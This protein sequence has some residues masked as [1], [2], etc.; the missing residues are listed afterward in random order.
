M[1]LV[2]FVSAATLL[3][4]ALPA[5]AQEKL[6]AGRTVAKVEARPASITLRHQ[7]AYTQLLVSATL[8]NGDVVDVTRLAKFDMPAV[9]KASPAGL[10]RPTADGDGAIKVTVADK[11][12]A[13]PVKVS[14]LKVKY[15]V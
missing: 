8:D 14:G 9:V 15:E 13:V 7:F 2:R 5:A 12:V 6:P 11:S 1:R 4:L 3:V 10:V